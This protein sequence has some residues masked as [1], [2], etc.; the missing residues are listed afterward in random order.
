MPTIDEYLSTLSGVRAERIGAVVQYVRTQYPNAVEGMYIA[1][2]AQMP[3]FDID[4][5]GIGLGNMKNYV[6]IY[7]TK[8]SAVQIIADNNPKIKCGKSCANIRDSVDF[9]M[10]DI[11][12]AIDLCFEA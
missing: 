1:P 5:K 10:D 7:F 2:N 8:W 3:T 11:K 9:P 12:K 4:K 6:S